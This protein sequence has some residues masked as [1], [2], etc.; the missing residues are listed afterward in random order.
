[1]VDVRDDGDVPKIGSGGGGRSGHSHPMEK[2]LPCD[3][4]A[5]WWL[6]GLLIS[7]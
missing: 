4:A 7:G 1:V 6:G 3:S 5:A 2:A